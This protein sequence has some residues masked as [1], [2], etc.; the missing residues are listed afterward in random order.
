VVYVDKVTGK[1][2]SNKVEVEQKMIE[3]KER[4]F[5]IT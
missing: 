3:E 1:A 4:K 5:I 2:A